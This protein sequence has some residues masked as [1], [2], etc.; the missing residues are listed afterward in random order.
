M[1]TASLPPG[2]SGDASFYDGATL[3][4]TEPVVSSNALA[5]DGSSGLVDFGNHA[6]QNIGQQET[7]PAAS[8]S[9]WVNIEGDGTRNG[10]VLIKQDAEGDQSAAYGLIYLRA[11]G[12]NHLLLGDGR[13]RRLARL[14]IANDPG[15][16]HLVQRGGCL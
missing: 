3:L 16:E 2:A 10:I 8:V 5:F 6:W 4:G 15:P 9:A 12:Q 11:D 1:L 14:S 7:T 13:E